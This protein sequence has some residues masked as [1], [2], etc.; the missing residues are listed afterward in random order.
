[1]SRRNSGALLLLRDSF[2]LK[3][4]LLRRDRGVCSLCGLNTF[5]LYAAIG[6]VRRH[7]IAWGLSFA[8]FKNAIGPNARPWPAQLWEMDHIFSRYEGGSDSL[9]NLRTLCIACH[10]EESRKLAGLRKKPRRF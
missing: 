8:M 5:D 2:E 3:D 1:M 9:D 6:Y 4:A 7:A 10:K